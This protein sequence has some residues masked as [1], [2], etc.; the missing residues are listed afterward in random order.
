ML[1][2]KLLQYSYY[3]NEKFLRMS[4]IFFLDFILFTIVD[5]CTIYLHIAIN[6]L[7]HDASF[8]YYCDIMKRIADIMLQI[9]WQCL[10]MKP[11]LTSNTQ[12]LY[13]RLPNARIKLL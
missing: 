8:D 2:L 4:W 13:H 6:T 1:L 7:K 5:T 12:Y 11:M 3:E 9:Q 10:T